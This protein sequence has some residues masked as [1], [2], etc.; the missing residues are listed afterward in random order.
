MKWLFFPLAAFSFAF[1]VACLH[2][3]NGDKAVSNKVDIAT[4]YGN[5]PCNAC[6]SC[7]YCKWCKAGGTCGI[8][9]SQ[10]KSKS[11]TYK[12]PLK[13]SGR[14]QAITKKGT[15]CSRSAR[16]NGYCWQHSG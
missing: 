16:S 12:A 14:C 7:N 11:N 15:Q 13:T 10:K 6:T 8:C 4:C 9:A 3:S 2:S 1:N 5:T